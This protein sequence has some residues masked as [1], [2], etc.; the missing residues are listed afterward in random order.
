MKRI[1]LMTVFVCFAIVLDAQTVQKDS[2]TAF[3]KNELLFESS[4]PAI[5]NSNMGVMYRRNYNEFS[6]RVRVNGN[7]HNYNAKDIGFNQQ[8]YFM[9]A[10]MGI[11]KNVALTKICQFYWGGDLFYS[12]RYNSYTAYDTYYGTDKHETTI[13]SFGL[14]PVVGIKLTFRR[15]VMGVENSGR[16]AL[17]YKNNSYKYSDPNY[18]SHSYFQN[19]LNFN[20]SNGV[21]FFVGFNF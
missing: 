15:F 5:I 2:S 3:R 9:Y 16:L 20:P 19:S 6:L 4:N 21:R 13:N 14:S 1:F 7:Y 12:Q 11:Q 18:S 10:A 8:R 17:D